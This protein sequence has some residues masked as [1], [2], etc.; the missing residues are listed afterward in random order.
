MTKTFTA[1]WIVPIIQPPI[2]H[3]YIRLNGNQVQ[4]LGTIK[5]KPTDTIDLGDVALLPGLVNAHTHLEFSHL[6]SPIG[7]PGIEFN[8]WID[9]VIKSR[10]TSDPSLS[11]HSVLQGAQQCESY[12]VRLAGDIATPPPATS[13]STDGNPT[14][15][16]DKS[17]KQ[18]SQ[19][20]APEIVSFAEVIGLSHERSQERLSAAAKHYSRV[21]H[22]GISPH[23]PYSTRPEAIEACV[24]FSASNNIPLAMHLAESPAEREL[25]TSGTGPLAETLGD[26]GLLTAGIFPAPRNSMSDWLTLLSGCSRGLVIHGNDLQADELE[27]F[28]RYRNLTAVYCPRTHNFFRFDHHPIADMIQAGIRVALG[29][30]SLASNPDLSLWNEVR[31]VLNRRQDIDPSEVLKMAT[32]NGAWALGRTDVGSFSIGSEPGLISL[33]TQANSIGQLYED[34]ASAIPSTFV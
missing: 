2:Q 26:L 21:H 6:D 22:S 8:K 4:E 7:H 28:S 5:N 34:F 33:D 11:E 29:T 1:R 23:A 18:V 24:D 10:F 14:D 9:L 30:D 20:P 27:T 13:S 17:D 3:G 15:S 31:F 32:V 12:G 16:P 25:L 19:S